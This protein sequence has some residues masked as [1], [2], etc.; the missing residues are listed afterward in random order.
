MGSSTTSRSR[1]RLQPGTGSGPCCSRKSVALREVLT[2]D[3]DDRSERNDIAAGLW[4]FAQGYAHLRTGETDFA[5]VYLERV[6]SSAATSEDVLRFHDA[7]HI[8]G[9]VVSGKVQMH[10]ATPFAEDVLITSREPVAP[11][12]RPMVVDH[13]AR[14]RPRRPRYRSSHSIRAL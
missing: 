6:R 2:L 9:I 7:E 12:K 14:Q 4:D 1:S 3:R 5:Q 13:R 10:T 11:G 8:L